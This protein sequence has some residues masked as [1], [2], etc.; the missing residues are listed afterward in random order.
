MNDER[1]HSPDDDHQEKPGFLQVLQ[2]VLAAI[3]GV[4]SSKNRERDFKKGDAS[5]YMAVF[6]VLVIGLVITMI[7]VVNIVLSSAGQ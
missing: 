7:V 2:S 1:K 3:F 5:Q 6:A 4:Q